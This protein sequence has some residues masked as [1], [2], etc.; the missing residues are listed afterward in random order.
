V[1]LIVEDI[2]LMTWGSCE[3]M[4]IGAVKI[5]LLLK[6]VNGIFPYFLHLLSNLDNIQHMSTKLYWVIVNFVLVCTIKATLYFEVL[7]N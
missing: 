3:F 4:E 2:Y 7:M 6:G 1:T 5:I